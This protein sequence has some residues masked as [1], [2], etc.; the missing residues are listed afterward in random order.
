MTKA[1]AMPVART[2]QFCFPQ[3]SIDFHPDI[4]TASYLRE[5]NTS[6]ALRLAIN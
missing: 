2:A 3:C 6:I 5:G 1:T 4:D